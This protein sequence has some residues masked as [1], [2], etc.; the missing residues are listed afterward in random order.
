MPL[1]NIFFFFLQTATPILEKL[2]PYHFFIQYHLFRESCKVHNGQ[3]VKDLSYINR[4]LSKV[5]V[6]DTEPEVLPGHM[7]NAVIVPKWK[8]QPGDKGLVSLIPFLE[9]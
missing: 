5:I 6:L 7:N 4:D 2:D 8:G 9:C 3:V 1:S